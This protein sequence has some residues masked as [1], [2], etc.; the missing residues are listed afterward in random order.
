MAGREGKLCCMSSGATSATPL[1]EALRPTTQ[2]ISVGR[3]GCLR[4]DTRSALSRL[5]PLLAVGHR[6]EM[7][8]G[9][10]SLLA[11]IWRMGL[12]RHS[13]D[14]HDVCE[15]SG[16]LNGCSHLSF[17]CSSRFKRLKYLRH[18]CLTTIT[19]GNRDFFFVFC[20]IFSEEHRRSTINTV[21]VRIIHM[22]PHPQS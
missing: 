6:G 2:P 19:H 18:A 11:H 15:F 5:H 20:S 16:V 17:C 10:T 22:R 9:S 4:R 7:F 14:G 8:Y 13:R 1:S 12:I 21:P 3:N